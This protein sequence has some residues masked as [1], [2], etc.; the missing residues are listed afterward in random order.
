MTT[1]ASATAASNA[2][3]VY[4][5]LNAGA[6]GNA[7]GGSSAASDAA[8][9]SDRFMTLLVAQLKNQD[10]MAP[11]DN[12]QVTSQMAQISTVSGI[13]KLNATIGTMTS[14]FGQMQALQSVSLVGRGVLVEGKDM[15]LDASGTGHAAV[16]LAG[17]ADSVKVEVL[18]TAGRVVDTLNLGAQ[19]SGRHGIDWTPPAGSDAGAAYTFRVSALSGTTA[20]ASTLLERQTVTAV[21]SS[22]GSLSLELGDGRSVGYADVRAFD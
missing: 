9:M 18:N 10:P 16:D 19:G 8:A 7:A 14:Q 11:M 22:N 2:A 17:A 4:A 21:S 12:A 5:Q 20:V 6:S 13:D 15:N 1:T 3:A